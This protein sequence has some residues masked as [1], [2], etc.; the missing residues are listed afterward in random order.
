MVLPPL[1]AAILVV[2]VVFFVA[3]AILHSIHLFFLILIVLFF[4]VLFFGVSLS[5]VSAWFS[6]HE[7]LQLVSNAV[8]NSLLFSFRGS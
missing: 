6:A 4:L 5:D 2:L 7:R 1:I 8:W 3:R